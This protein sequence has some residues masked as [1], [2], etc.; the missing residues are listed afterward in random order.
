MPSI[1][2]H[3]QKLRGGAAAVLKEGCRVLATTFLSLLLPLSFLLLARLSTARYFLSVGLADDYILIQ[4]QNEVSFLTSLFLYSGTTLVLSLLVSLITVAALITHL[5][6]TRH[7]HALL[8]I[9]QRHRLYAAWLLLFLMQV[10]L[11]LGIQGT[12]EAEI[13]S[14]TVGRLVLPR[15]LIFA[16]GLHETTVFW[17]EMVVKPVVDETIFGFS[18]E[19]FWWAEKMALAVAFGNL[20]WRRLREEAEALV[21]LPRVTAELKMDVAVADVLGW[22]LYYLTVA[23]GGVRVVKGFLWMVTWILGYRVSPARQGDTASEKDGRT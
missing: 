11:S 8:I 20:W 4:P 14:Y 7:K 5:I 6:L 1:H 15:R 2:Q 19:G 16:L 10:C 23:I 18:G 21:V 12:V 17:R 22:S 13:N 3:P 9:S